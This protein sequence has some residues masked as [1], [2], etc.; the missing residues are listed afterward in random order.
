MKGLFKFLFITLI[1]L[2]MVAFGFWYYFIRV[3]E[4]IVAE[5]VSEQP[6]F[7]SEGK[8]ILDGQSQLF[9]F[10][11]MSQK[12][13][14]L[15][16]NWR[17]DK[18]LRF[19]YS[20]WMTIPF[21][22]KERM[23]GED[24]KEI[25]F[26]QKST[27]GIIEEFLKISKYSHRIPSERSQ[28]SQGLVN[29]SFLSDFKQLI[30]FHASALALEGK[31]REV[32][33]LI[34]A[35]LIYSEELSNL[36]GAAAQ[37][38]FMVSHIR[39][40]TILL[41]G[42]LLQAHSLSADDISSLKIIYSTL[43]N[44][45]RQRPSQEQIIKNT[46]FKNEIYFQDLAK[47]DEKLRQAANH[48]LQA[49][50]SL[51]ETQLDIKSSLRVF[52]LRHF[53]RIAFAMKHKAEVERYL[54]D[55]NILHHNPNSSESLKLVNF[56]KD[57]HYIQDSSYFHLGSVIIALALYSCDYQKYP[58]SLLELKAQGY[59][60]KI[61]EDIFLDVFFDKQPLRYHTESNGYT[62]QSGNDIFTKPTLLASM[63]VAK[64]YG[65]FPF[66]KSF[67]RLK[68]ANNF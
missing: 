57:T 32:W 11:R 13:A 8:A 61:P 59:L 34:N 31:W 41:L 29:I 30:L 26:F 48:S 49:I 50:Q 68:V 47:D 1:F 54:T 53:P 7:V 20:H 4:T 21:F 40:D 25:R 27:S 10:I 66:A 19:V 45:Y 63:S 51:S 46:I 44:I 2:G 64:K 9:E 24:L 65:H 12:F 58:I 67:K 33:P 5:V 37:E 62:L 42:K 55:L 56:E 17:K 35:T 15:Q 39:K 22:N 18:K 28:Y 16:E 36:S 38:I 14:A 60:D 6:K 23:S 52:L 43:E 3:D